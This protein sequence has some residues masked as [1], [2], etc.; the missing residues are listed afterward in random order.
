MKKK[1]FTPD[2]T[3]AFTS[4]INIKEVK[5]RKFNFNITRPSEFIH[6][7][8]EVPFCFN[9]IEKFEKFISN[10]RKENPNSISFGFKQKY[11][12]S[13]QTDELYLCWS[14]QN[15]NFE[16][17]LEQYNKDIKELEQIITDNK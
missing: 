17:E 2:F 12:F 10:F 1:F 7:S 6:K 16:Q 13:S 5:E 4:S 11:N 14:E 9:S 8:I 15:P 3:P